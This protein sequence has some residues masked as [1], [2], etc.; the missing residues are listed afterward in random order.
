MLN[1][2]NLHYC[3]RRVL[4]VCHQVVALCF[5]YILESLD[6]AAILVIDEQAEVPNCG[7]AEYHFDPDPHGLCIPE[8]SLWNYGVPLDAEGAPKTS[9]K[10]AVTGTR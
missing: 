5:R 2:I 8:P 3:D 7:I 4:I 1:T 6:E 10:D 9:A